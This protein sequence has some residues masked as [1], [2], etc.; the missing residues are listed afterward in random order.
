[1]RRTFINVLSAVI[2]FFA[3]VSSASAMVLKD[4][5]AQPGV[6]RTGVIIV[7]VSSYIGDWETTELGTFVLI[8]DAYAKRLVET[9]MTKP[10]VHYVVLLTGSEATASGMTTALTKAADEKLDFLVFS[11]R[12]FGLGADTHESCF[13]AADWDHG[14]PW[15]TCLPAK[16]VAPLVTAAA[17][18]RLV[19]LD[20]STPSAAITKAVGADT[21]GSTADDW[22]VQDDQDTTV[23]SSGRTQKYTAC[24]A[25]SPMIAAIVKTVAPETALTY[26]DL[27]SGLSA[28]ASSPPDKLPP[29][30]MPCTTPIQP[31]YDGTWFSDVVLIPAVDMPKPPDTTIVVHTTDPL[32]T[33]LPK[34][35][36]VK[37]LSTPTVASLVTTGVCAAVGIGSLAYGESRLAEYND[38]DWAAEHYPGGDADRIAAG[39]AELPTYGYIAATGLTCAVGGAAASGLTWYFGK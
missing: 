22:P 21:F 2:C 18:R 11:Y 10:G 28:I 24:N 8:D 20:A 34:A 39:N 6:P 17:K 25:F 5:D 38:A 13:A 30:I 26:G 9:F 27:T 33:E 16:K 37:R 31:S 35:P 15:K 19:L 23:V 36:K 29:G 7:A 32:P 1:M 14:N 3:S 12:G 4:V